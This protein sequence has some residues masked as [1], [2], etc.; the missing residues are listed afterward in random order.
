M[1]Q[2]AF[3]GPTE[4]MRAMNLQLRVLHRTRKR[5]DGAHLG[6][7]IAVH[8][9]R[10]VIGSGSECN[11]RCPSSTISEYRC[12]IL[13]Q[14]NGIYLRDLRSETGTFL[15][16]EKITSQRL[17][18]NGDHLQLGKLEFEVVLTTPV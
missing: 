17:I 8:G 18:A 9:K 13:A 12:E 16:G 6:S 11:M 10:F 4:Q 14:E 3:A 5:Q 15:N 7:D 2:A 1:K